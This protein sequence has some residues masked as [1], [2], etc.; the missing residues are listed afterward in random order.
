[1]LTEDHEEQGEDNNHAYETDAASERHPAGLGWRR[2][3]VTSD[4]ASDVRRDG[5]GH[6]VPLMVA[7]MADPPLPPRGEELL[8]L[9]VGD[10]HRAGHR[11]GRHDQRHHADDRD[12]GA[13][14][15]D[16]VLHPAVVDLGQPIDEAQAGSDHAQPPEADEQAA[17]LARLDLRLR[18]WRAERG[19]VGHLDALGRRGAYHRR[20]ATSYAQRQTSTGR[21]GRHRRGACGERGVA[22]LRV[23]VAA[24]RAVGRGRDRCVD[25]RSAGLGRAGLRVHGDCSFDGPGGF[26]GD[27]ARGESL[28]GR[29]RWSA[30]GRVT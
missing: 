4:V 24:A 18:R 26:N 15:D 16:V 2:Y 19:Q 1:M 25:R 30:M 9:C 8:V 12:G 13:L 20:E 5:C 27:V 21:G 11:H 17:D 10:L 22:W 6:G 23:G 28:M 29:W 14:H 3:F 7:A